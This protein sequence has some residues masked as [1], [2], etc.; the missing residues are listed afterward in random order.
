MG[1]RFQS[2]MGI[3]LLF[4]GGSVFLLSETLVAFSFP[5]LNGYLLHGIDD[6]GSKIAFVRN[7][8][9]I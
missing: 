1:C 8:G 2:A 4:K 7:C 6:L 5:D 9:Q 3:F